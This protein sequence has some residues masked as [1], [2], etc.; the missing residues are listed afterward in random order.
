MFEVFFLLLIIPLPLTYV[1]IYLILTVFW[2]DL[3]TVFSCFS[4]QPGFY[5]NLFT[6]S[7]CLLLYLKIIFILP[8]FLQGS[9]ARQRTSKVFSFS[10]LRMLSHFLLIPLVANEKSLLIWRLVLMYAVGWWISFLCQLS[11]FLLYLW[12]SEVWLW[13]ALD[14]FF[15][16]KILVDSHFYLSS[17][18]CC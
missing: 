5:L 17:S 13:H 10:I 3:W 2:T 4:V 6:I 8:S 12:F 1:K 7:S 14:F 18:F 11:V 9:F 16:N 15:G